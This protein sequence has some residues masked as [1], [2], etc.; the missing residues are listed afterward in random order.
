MYWHSQGIHVDVDDDFTP[1]SFVH[2]V[3][4]F[5]TASGPIIRLQSASLANVPL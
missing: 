3:S 4:G 2:M 1:I 5:Y